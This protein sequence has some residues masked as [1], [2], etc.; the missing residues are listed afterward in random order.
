MTVLL[1]L[2][3]KGRVALAPYRSLLVRSSIHASEKDSFL[4][5]Q[6][7]LHGARHAG[8]RPAHGP[9]SSLIPVQSLPCC[10]P[11]STARSALGVHAEVTNEADGTHASVSAHHFVAQKGAHSCL[12]SSREEKRGFSAAPANNRQR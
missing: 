1:L 4:L 7:E 8:A 12:L 3:G 2:P 9:H 5:P 6:V 11:G 10:I